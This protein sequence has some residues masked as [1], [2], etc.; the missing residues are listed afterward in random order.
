[1]SC[2]TAVDS[3]MFHHLVS[4]NLITTE[5]IKCFPVWLHVVSSNEACGWGLTCNLGYGLKHM[6][7]FS[8]YYTNSTRLVQYALFRE[9]KSISLTWDSVWSQNRGHPS[10]HVF[11]HCSPWP[12]ELLGLWTSSGT[13]EHTEIAHGLT[14]LPLMTVHKSSSTPLSNIGQHS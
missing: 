4:S 14:K 7:C 5:E 12:N 8:I 6:G 9:I 13:S 11:Q 10:S 2:S 3:P 1:M